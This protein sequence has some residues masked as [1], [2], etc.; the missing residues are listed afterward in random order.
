LH[1]SAAAAEAID[2]GIADPESG[3]DIDGEAHDVG[4]PDLGA[5]E[6]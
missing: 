1:L 3:L 4:S 2:Q 6:R 5:D